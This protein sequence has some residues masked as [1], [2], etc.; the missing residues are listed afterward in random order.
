MVKLLTAQRNSN[1]L[2][3]L[4][5]TPPKHR[6]TRTLSKIISADGNVTDVNSRESQDSST[7][8]TLIPALRQ[9]LYLSLE[10]TELD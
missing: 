1:P 10:A 9:R 8:I 5:R 6:D 2:V 4:V 7:A 3:K